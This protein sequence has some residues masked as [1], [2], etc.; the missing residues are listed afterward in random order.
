MIHSGDFGL[1][2]AVWLLAGSVAINILYM[3][4]DKAD[5][6]EIASVFL[7][8]V[9]GPFGFP[10]MKACQAFIRWKNRCAVARHRRRKAA[11]MRS[12]RREMR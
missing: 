2:I 12:N 4:Q 9:L 11:E 1:W 10:F 6:G 7:L 3:V 5:A 8:V